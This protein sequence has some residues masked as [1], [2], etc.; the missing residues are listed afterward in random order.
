MDFTCS[1]EVN[2]A[3]AKILLPQNACDAGLPANHSVTRPSNPETLPTT[4]FS[5]KSKGFSGTLLDFTCSAE[6]N[7]ACAKILLPQNACDAGL[8]ANHS[9]TRSSN[10][11]TLPTTPF[12]QKSKGFSGTLLD[13]TCSTEVNSACAKILL[14]QNACDAGLPAN[15][16]VTRSSNP[17]TLPATPF[18]RPP[19]TGDPRRR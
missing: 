8:P 11:E 9:V 13:F 4:P 19:A 14:A 7:S 15:H 12:S 5:Q 18:P 10:P 2:S 16:S 1:A 17:E 3:C 6:V